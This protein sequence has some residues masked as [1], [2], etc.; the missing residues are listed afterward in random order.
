M[1]EMKNENDESNTKKKNEDFFAKLDNDRIDKGCE[2]AV[3]PQF[4]I[5]IITLLKNA[6]IYVPFV[7]KKEEIFL[8]NIIPSRRYHKKYNKE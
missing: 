6:T 7:M 5:P 1:F 4:F 3:H 8:K 2:Y